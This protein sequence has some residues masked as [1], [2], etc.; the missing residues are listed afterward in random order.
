MK[1]ADEQYSRNIHSRGVNFLFIATLFGKS[2]C[3][4][5]SQVASGRVEKREEFLCR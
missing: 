2:G 3:M 4:A 5:G 1:E